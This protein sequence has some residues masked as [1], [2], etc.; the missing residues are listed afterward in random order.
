MLSGTENINMSLADKD[1]RF[2]TA[3]PSNR[4]QRPTLYQNPLGVGKP[5]KLCD[6]RCIM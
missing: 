2:S 3:V 4:C 6:G 5:P 1:F